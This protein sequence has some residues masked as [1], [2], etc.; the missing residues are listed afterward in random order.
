MSYP[1]Q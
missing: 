1:A